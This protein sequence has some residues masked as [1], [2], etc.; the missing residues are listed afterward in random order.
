MAAVTVATTSCDNP[1]FRY[2]ILKKMWLAVCDCGHYEYFFIEE[3]AD[4]VLKKDHSNPKRIVTWL[5]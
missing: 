4:A 2:D 3:A 5:L 1:A